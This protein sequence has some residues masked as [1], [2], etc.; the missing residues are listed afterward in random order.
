MR[1]PQNEAVAAAKRKKRRRRLATWVG[2]WLREMRVERD[3][4]SGDALADIA[5]RLNRDVSSVCRIEKGQ[6]KLTADELP[7]VLRAYGLTPEQF[8]ERAARQGA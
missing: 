2:P 4:G 8:A 5:K 1:I 3:R 6:N 7:R